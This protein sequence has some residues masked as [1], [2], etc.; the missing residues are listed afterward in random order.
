M[1]I[2]NPLYDHAFK[3]LMSNERL[4][5][6]VLSVLLEKKVLAVE[7]SQQEVVVDDEARNFTMY[8]L[9]FKAQIEDEHGN[10]ETVLIEL[11]KSKLPT[12][13]LRFRR[14]LSHSYAQSHKVEEDGKEIQKI[15][16]IIAIYLLG[17]NLSD[18]SEMAVIVD[19]QI[20]NF[21]SKEVLEVED[22]FTKYLTHKCIVLQVR[23]LPEKRQSRIEK[24]MSLF[25]QAWIADQ[26]YI[27]DLK[28]VP[29]EFKDLAEYLTRPLIDNNLR[30]KLE[31]E[32]EVEDLFAR[33]EAELRLAK[34]ESKRA[35]I[36]E[37]E[38]RLR[39]EEARLREE[40]AKCR[41]KEAKAKLHQVVCKLRKQ[42][43]PIT[44]IASFVGLTIAET[45]AI[46]C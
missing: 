23:R 25:N 1:R 10:V 39:E 3:Y 32:Q 44:E 16:P 30:Q 27:L 17:Y 2:A 13:L 29:E 38:A 36:R 7:L 26:N 42:G 31:V 37:E 19:N 41:E 24:F 21:D 45:E 34:E 28:E 43:M 46:R 15:Y 5:R 6:K 14:Y 33:Q 4:A 12:N 18:I 9:D 20:K 8:R 35:K 11:Q 22:D 40:E